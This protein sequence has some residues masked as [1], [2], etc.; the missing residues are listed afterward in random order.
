MAETIAHSLFDDVAEVLADLGNA[1][2][3]FLGQLRQLRLEL[4][5][6]DHPSDL[7]GSPHGAPEKSA[8]RPLEQSDHTT[9]YRSS[10]AASAPTPL[11]ND[12]ITTTTQPAAATPPPRR[13]VDRLVGSNITTTTA[14]AVAPGPRPR[15]LSRDYDFFTDL[16]EKL[17]LLAETGNPDHPGTPPQ[18][19]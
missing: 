17:R 5:S 2:N 9:P 4:S 16:E 6:G 14:A 8:V 3:R 7:M 10:G 11:P 13:G 19:G 15:T 12:L 18:G 1:Q